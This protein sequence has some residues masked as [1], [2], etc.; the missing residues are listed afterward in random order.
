MPIILAIPIAPGCRQALAMVPIRMRGRTDILFVL[1]KCKYASN[2]MDVFDH[3]IA[4]YG[5]ITPE[6]ARLMPKPSL[7]TKVAPFE[8]NSFVT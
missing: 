5:S 1:L 4:T 7:S 8:P 6:V 2:K 3:V